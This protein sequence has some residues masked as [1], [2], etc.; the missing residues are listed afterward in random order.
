MGSGPGTFIYD[1]SKYKD[2]SFNQNPFWNVRFEGANSKVLTVLATTGVL[3]ILSILALMGFFVFYGIKFLFRKTFSENEGF[4]WMLGAGIFISFITLSVGFFLYHSNLT[5]DFLFF[6]LMGS[7]V[8]LLS[9]SRKEVLLKP[10]SLS[11][12]GVTFAFT[13]VFIF[14]LGLFILEGQRYVAGRSYLQGVRAW[15]QG[16]NDDAMNNLERA[17]GINRIG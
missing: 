15:Q 5:L 8:V 10:S 14:G 9:Q 17:A 2:V 7:F 12:L 16:R 11:M 3:G 6:L 4:Y 13:L 1:F